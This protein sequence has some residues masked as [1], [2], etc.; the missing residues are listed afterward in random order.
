M[1]RKRIWLRSRAPLERSG[2]RTRRIHCRSARNRGAPDPAAARVSQL[3]ASAC[4]VRAHSISCTV[5]IL[6][7]RPRAH[8]GCAVRKIASSARASAPSAGSPRRRLSQDEAGRL[9]A[10]MSGQLVPRAPPR[11]FRGGRRGLFPFPISV[12]SST[13]PQSRFPELSW[14]RRAERAEAVCLLPSRHRRRCL[15]CC[16][17]REA[18][19]AS[20]SGLSSQTQA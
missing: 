17:G 7:D 1:T 18:S 8:A 6:V 14:A 19:R 10:A 20:A 15:V 5:V 16:L 11:S 3:A 12:S 4:P 9:V 2:V 13:A